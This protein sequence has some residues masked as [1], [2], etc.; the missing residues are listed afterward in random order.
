MHLSRTRAPLSFM[1]SGPSGR[2]HH[3]RHQLCFWRQQVTLK[4]QD[5]FQVIIDISCGHLIF[6]IED[7][8]NVGNDGGR[9][10]PKIRRIVSW[11][12]GICDQCLP[13]NMKSHLSIIW[14]QYLSKTWNGYVSLLNLR[15]FETLEIW[16]V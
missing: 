15:N 14:D 5:L 6:E 12:S 11:K 10:N 3:S 4:S 1:V 16:N 13:E 2:D 7:F 8:E 9:R